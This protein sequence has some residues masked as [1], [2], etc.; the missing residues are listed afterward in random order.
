MLAMILAQASGSGWLKSQIDV[1]TL[2][3]VIMA[4]VL[5]FEGYQKRK[6]DKKITTI[7]CPNKVE[8]LWEAIGAI[9]K[10]C[11]GFQD[12]MGKALK[13]LE[14]QDSDGIPR[15]YARDQGKVM[16]AIGREI[17]GR[18]SALDTALEVLKSKV[19]GGRGGQ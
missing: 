14:S 2:A 11:E 5:A 18:I 9:Q 12:T 8:G 13:V 16:I 19:N 1:P 4:A 10:C 15:V 3:A 7:V 6:Q 17:L